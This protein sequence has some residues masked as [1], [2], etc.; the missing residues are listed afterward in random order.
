MSSSKDCPGVYA[1]SW[2]EVR[3]LL[4]SDS[5]GSH[6]WRGVSN[7]SWCMNTS[8]DRFATDNQLPDRER[9]KAAL[10]RNYRRYS[11]ELGADRD[12]DLDESEAW[13]LGQHWGLPTTLL[14][15]SESPMVA[16]F[17]ALS[18][19]QA[20]ADVKGQRACVYRLVE[21]DATPGD[22]SYVKPQR[23][24]NNAR[25][26]AQS[27]LFT[28]TRESAC[29]IDV[30]KRLNRLDDIFAVSFPLEVRAIGLRELDLMQ[31]NDLS[32]YPDRA[33]LVRHVVT[34]ALREGV[35]K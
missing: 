26:R 14:D 33:G 18:S 20:Y 1:E 2:P 27:G 34:A 10:L 32:I 30:L 13:A 21:R 15:W 28:E 9:L 8:L 4:L 5:N 12:A 11:H 3:N 23:S 25:M 22:L 19:S 24:A 16:A 35:G 6:Y 29:L 17:F 31:I 7:A